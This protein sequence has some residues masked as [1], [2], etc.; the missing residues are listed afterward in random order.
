M[1]VDDLAHLYQLHLLDVELIEM[2]QRAMALDEH[3]QILQRVKALQT[4]HAIVLNLPK[5]LE[6]EAG[7]LETKANEYRAKASADEK[8]LFGGSVVNPKEAA[9]YESEIKDLRTKADE[10]EAKYL[11]ILEQIDPAK[12]EAKPIETEIRKLAKAF[13]EVKARE[14]QEG[15]DLQVRYKAKAEARPAL[16]KAVSGNLYTQYEAI[17]GKHGYAM[18]VVKDSK[19]GA[20]GTIL[21]EKILQ[22]LD[23]DRL[24]TCEQCHR[25]LFK[26]VSGS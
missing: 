16:A 3:R 25:I 8:K 21:A 15:A 12:S 7:A 5:K 14:I 6:T 20:C 24:S 11:E 13:E 22:A 9:A 26:P 17:R 18:G 19:C 4:E 10:A 2:K 1:P 23:L